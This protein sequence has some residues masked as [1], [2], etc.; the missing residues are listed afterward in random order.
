MNKRFY[1]TA[2]ATSMLFSSV[3]SASPY[4]S[5]ENEEEYRHNNVTVYTA[6]VDSLPYDKIV[7]DAYH[8]RKGDNHLLQMQIARSFETGKFEVPTNQS[9]ALK[10]YNKAASNG[11]PHGAYK[12]Y[13]YTKNTKDAEKGLEW[14]SFA[15]NNGHVDALFEMGELSYEGPHMSN[16]DLQH[17]LSF[18]KKAQDKGHPRAYER[19][20]EIEREVKKRSNSEKWENFWA[21]FK[22]SE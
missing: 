12:V 11:N 20:Y 1:L 7:N 22:M 13:E 10:W 4:S 19:I 16:K 17:S 9:E 18:F 6:D 2:I 8:N 21:P 3:A 14:L 15:A 5:W